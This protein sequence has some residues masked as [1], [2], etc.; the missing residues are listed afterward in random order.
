MHILSEEQTKVFLDRFAV[1]YRTFKKNHI[2][3]YNK[4]DVFHYAEGIIDF[5]DSM[6]FAS[7]QI[8]YD[9]SSLRNAVCDLMEEIDIE[10]ESKE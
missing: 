1:Q 6:I 7:S 8:T 9:M 3:S 2:K 10:D 4:D 5:C